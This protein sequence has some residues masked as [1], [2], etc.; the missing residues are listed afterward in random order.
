MLKAVFF[1]DLLSICGTL[2]PGELEE[3]AVPSDP[4]QGHPLGC[5]FH[6]R[7]LL[8]RELGWFGAAVLLTKAWTCRYNSISLGFVGEKSHQ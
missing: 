1:L 5:P 7:A 8:K 4:S 6:P 2:G 3:G